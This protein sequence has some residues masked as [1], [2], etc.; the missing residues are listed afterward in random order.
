M[1][2]SVSALR[3][4][5]LD[6]ATLD[7]EV[8][9]VIDAQLRRFLESIPGYDF[10][11]L[12]PEFEAALKSVF[13][14]FIFRNE[15][16]TVGQLMMDMSYRRSKNEVLGRRGKWAYFVCTVVLPWIRQRIPTWAGRTNAARKMET[17]R[18]LDHCA[19]LFDTINLI[20]FLWFLNRGGFRTICERL[21]GFRAVHNTRPALDEID[22]E[23]MEREL[24][25]HGFSDILIF[26]VPLINYRRFYNAIARF[27]KRIRQRLSKTKDEEVSTQG[28]DKVIRKADVSAPCAY[29]EQVPPVLPCHLGCGHV[30]C[31][32]CLAANL[33]SDPNFAC[34]ICG[35]LK[36]DRCLILISGNRIGK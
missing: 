32:Y 13:W 35:Y 1:D 26:F 3:V 24:L 17:E 5:Q 2:E 11:W 33:E 21:L 7:K 28:A 25:W 15:G 22:T 30:Y 6:S 16:A 20:H 19:S 14:Y 8:E 29:C 31:Y 18:F 34:L 9:N 4:S 36:S 12:E 27:G 10:S 23:L